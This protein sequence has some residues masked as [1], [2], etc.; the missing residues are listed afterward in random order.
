[1]SYQ[2]SL[3]KKAAKV[4]ECLERLQGSVPPQRE[5]LITLLSLDNEQELKLLFAAADARRG[6]GVVSLR[7]YSS[8]QGAR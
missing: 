4:A 1:M 5:D 2:T 3:M 8:T 6:H 7:Y